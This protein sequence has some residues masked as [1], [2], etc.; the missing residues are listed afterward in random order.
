MPILILD[1]T[2][3]N[4]YG[5]I[6][7]AFKSDKNLIKKSKSKL[8]TSLPN[9]KAFNDGYNKKLSSTTTTS[10]YLDS[11]L[12]ENGDILESLLKSK[13]KSGKKSLKDIRF[14]SLDSMSQRQTPKKIFI[15]IASRL[16]NQSVI[17]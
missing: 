2:I 9:L 1:R 6:D 14:S 12:K 11:Y 13:L 17:I 10:S 8:D 3:D 15:N 4:S 16:S 7:N 5:K